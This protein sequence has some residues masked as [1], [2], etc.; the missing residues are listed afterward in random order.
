MH[1][2][3]FPG[4]ADEL[5]ILAARGYLHCSGGAGVLLFQAGGGCSDLQDGCDS[6]VAGYVH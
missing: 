2:W 3:G 6:L 4:K 5:C 1:Y